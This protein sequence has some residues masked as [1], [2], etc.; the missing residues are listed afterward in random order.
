MLRPN[1]TVG[2]RSLS[3]FC[4]E[5]LNT[6]AKHVYRTAAG[7]MGSFVHRTVALDCSYV[8]T[9]EVVA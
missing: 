1:R 3:G 2:V 5:N 6:A 7:K 4:E 9:G 8:S